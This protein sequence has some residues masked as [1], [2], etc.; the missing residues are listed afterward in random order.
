MVR[1][2]AAFAWSISWL[3]PRI[4]PPSR[5]TLRKGFL[6]MISTRVRLLAAFAASVLL[7]CDFAPGVSAQQPQFCRGTFRLARLRH[8]GD[9]NLAPQALPNLSRSIRDKLKFNIVIDQKEL[10]PRDPNLV[11]YPLLYLHGRTAV[12]FS[13]EDK[14]SLRRHLSPGGGTLFADAS[15]GSA[16]FDASFRR[17]VADLL[18]G[19]PLGPIPQTDDLYNKKEG[20][21]NLAHAR[22]TAAA[23]GEAGFPGLEG[24]RI[25]GHWAVIYSRLDIG[26]A[27]EKPVD[28]GGKGFTNQSAL[29]IATNVVLDA[30]TP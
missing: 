29:E 10:F 7:T 19:H 6:A 8:A 25:D 11:Y 24:V 14:T 5:N 12:E 4:D 16:E 28:I 20:G 22:R 21:F 27:L 15:G 17:L 3:E 18:P 23:G 26:S 13:E 9:W 1:L 2:S 30:F